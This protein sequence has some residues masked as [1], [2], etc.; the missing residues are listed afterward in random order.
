M[1][2]EAKRGTL[3]QICLSLIHDKLQGG[4]SKDGRGMKVL[5][6][7]HDLQGRKTT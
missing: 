3:R 4:R 1:L 6:N 5:Y 2:G 7:A